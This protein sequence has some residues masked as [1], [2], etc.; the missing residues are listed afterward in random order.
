MALHERA[1][2]RPHSLNQS[3]AHTHTTPHQ[4]HTLAS[5]LH[6]T[7]VLHTQTP[8]HTLRDR[9]SNKEGRRL[10]AGYGESYPTHG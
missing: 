1:F 10:V 4:T 3:H 9:H 8:P 5:R 2:D 7:L 6:T